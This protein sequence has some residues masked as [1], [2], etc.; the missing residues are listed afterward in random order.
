MHNRFFLPQAVLDRWIV[1]GKAD[2]VDAILVLTGKGR[3]YRLE[4]AVRVLAEVPA[5][6]DGKGLVGRVK[7]RAELERMGAEIIETSMLIGEEAYDVDPGW[8]AVPVR[9]ADGMGTEAS[10]RD[11]DVLATLAL[12]NDT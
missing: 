2:V 8:T 1:E 10:A 12:S 3:R 4:E 9:G 7:P 11:E 5:S 6:A